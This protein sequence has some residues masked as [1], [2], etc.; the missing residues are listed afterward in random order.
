MDAGQ[1][2]MEMPGIINQT[3]VESVCLQLRMV[4]ELIVFSSLVSNKDAWQKSQD[5][6]RK[7]WNIEK[8]MKDL[9]GIHGRY[10][11]EP[12]SKK[13]SNVSLP[14]EAEYS[15]SEVLAG[16]SLKFVVEPGNDYRP[17]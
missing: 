6:L 1:R 13:S 3:R 8:I 10:Y 17:C 2:L 9:R 5:E 16:D 4:L 15:G 12:N 11:P 14:S 7:A